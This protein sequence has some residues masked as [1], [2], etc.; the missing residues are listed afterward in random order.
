[1][2]YL[3]SNKVATLGNKM[4]KITNG[5]KSLS[6]IAKNKLE[7][8]DQSVPE[9]VSDKRLKTCLACPHLNK[10]MMQCKSCLCFVNFKIKINHES[11]PEG[12]WEAHE[13]EQ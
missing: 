13:T 1:M 12:K 9:E 4:K 3:L 2:L 11:C 7:G 6:K 8:Q 5:I 10:T